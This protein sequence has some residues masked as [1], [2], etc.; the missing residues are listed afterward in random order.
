[1]FSLVAH[2]CWW[3]EC[4]RDCVTLHVCVVTHL[5]LCLPKCKMKRQLSGVA[6]N[7]WKPYVGKDDPEGINRMG[8]RAIVRLRGWSDDISEKVICQQIFRV[9]GQSHADRI[10]VIADDLPTPV[11]SGE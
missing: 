2:F 7:E 11:F 9:V 3:M 8:K 5:C 1:M 6:M 4:L 10:T